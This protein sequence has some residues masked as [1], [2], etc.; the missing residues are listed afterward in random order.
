MLSKGAL[1]TLGFP[2]EVL[3]EPWGTARGLSLV[4][5]DTLNLASHTLNL[6]SHAL[7]LGGEILN[8][9]RKAKSKRDI[10]I[11]AAVGTQNAQSGVLGID[12]CSP[13]LL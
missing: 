9:T 12:R 8:L 4:S 6:A 10:M 2:Q 3:Q 11:P 7:K 13:K 5:G 1:G